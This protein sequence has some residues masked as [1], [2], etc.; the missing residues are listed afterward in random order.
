MHLFLD[1][2]YLDPLFDPPGSPCQKRHDYKRA[3]QLHRERTLKSSVLFPDKIPFRPH[4]H[5]RS[6]TFRLQCA[7]RRLI[8]PYI[9]AVVGDNPG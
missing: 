9:P 1:F 4:E 6:F 5:H 7:K 3:R 8:Y 2:Y